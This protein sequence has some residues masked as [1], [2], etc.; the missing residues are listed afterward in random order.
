MIERLQRK[1]HGTAPFEPDLA[2]Q[3]AVKDAQQSLENAVKTA[4]ATHEVVS[5]VREEEQ[6]NHFI[7]L[8]YGI[9]SRRTTT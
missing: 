7:E 4:T 8:I 2:A 1:V 6:R 9:D 5:S 3:R